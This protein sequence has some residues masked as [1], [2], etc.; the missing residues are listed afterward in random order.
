LLK[1]ISDHGVKT[2]AVTLHVG[3]GTFA[4]VRVAD[5]RRHSL[6]EEYTVIPQ[7]TADL[8]NE[9]RRKGGAVW[10]VGT[11]TVRTLEFGADDN[12]RLQAK[13][14]W[15]NLYIY[16]GYKFKVINHLITNFHLPGSSLLFLVAA[17]VGRKKLMAY[18]Q[19]AIARKY[20]FYSYGDAMAIIT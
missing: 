15:C 1:K 18:Y 12:G 11:T 17:L 6:H 7:K 16:P 13:E 14:D 5:I 2:A 8:V 10:A 3:Y 9:T 4:P 20:R 19:Q